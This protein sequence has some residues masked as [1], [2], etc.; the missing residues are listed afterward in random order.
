M[1]LPAVPETPVQ[2]SELNIQ[3]L[4]DALRRRKATFIQVFLV[5]LAVGIVASAPGKPLYQTQ[6][7]L[8]VPT[9]SY[10]MNIIDSS[11]PIAA[12]LAS[13]QPDSISTQLQDLQSSAFMDEAFRAAKVQYRPEVQPPSVSAVS[14]D[15]TNVIQITVEGGD[16]SEI[17]AL[18]NKVVELH[19]AKTSR[20]MVSGLEGTLQFVRGEKL[21]TDKQLADAEQQLQEFRQ[22]HRVSE[23]ASE[24]EGRAGEYAALLARMI[25]TE[26]NLTSTRTQLAG[27]KA[28]LAKE[29]AQRVEVTAKENPLISRFRDKLTDLRF[30]RMDLLREY[31]PTSRV[32]RDLDQQMAQLQEQMQAQPEEVPVRTRMPNA[33]RTFLQSRLEELETTLPALQESHN[34]AVA[35]FNARKGLLTGADQW[36]SDLTRLTRERDALQLAQNELADRMRDLEIRE[37][38]KFPTARII[39]YARAPGAPMPPRRTMSLG[40]SVILALLLAFGTVMLQEY[41]DDRVNSPDEV[42]RLT[43]LPTLAHVPLIAADQPRQIAA[44]PV[45][46]PVAESYRALRVAIGFAGVD[47]PIRRIQVTSPSKG[48]GKSTTSI[49]LATAMARDGK[50]VILVDADMRSPSIHRLFDLPGSPGLSEALAGMTRATES[51]QLTAIENLRVLPAGTVPPNPAEL[52]GSPTFSRVLEQLE[53]EA[54]VILFDTPPC[55]PVTDPVIIAARMDGVLLVLHSGQT[56]KASIRQSI[57]LLGRA[58]ARMV[59]AIF[60]QVQAHGRSYYY[61]HD[62]SYGQ[63]DARERAL[64]RRRHRNGKEPQSE[65]KRTGAMT[66]GIRVD[67]EEEV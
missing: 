14:V 42:E 58:R 60:N 17:A 40:L 65:L 45:N 61:Q 57:E 48:E 38:A 10:S 21:K 24:R 2:S 36:Q 15:G 11:N 41:L 59:G 43:G 52:L 35:R 51:L 39:E 53:A 16:P 18:A 8:L 33:N 64:P 25:E 50:Q 20:S 28:R 26:S 67:D 3:E 46:S 5:V 27:L 44:L 56:R 6:A 13:A 23:Q 49:N 4:L 7:K 9:G 63:G 1:S 54:D 55:M 37:R 31:H 34:A 19:Q 47:A 29:P 12:M 32:V 30:Q 62:Y 22:K 66:A